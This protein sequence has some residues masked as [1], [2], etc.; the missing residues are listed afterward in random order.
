MKNKFIYSIA[1]LFTLF[2][3]SCDRGDV[4]YTQTKENIQN[5][6]N[7]EII[8]R[9]DV[10]NNYNLIVYRDTIDNHVYYIVAN[11]YNGGVTMSHSEDCMCKKIN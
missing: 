5:D 11:R 2:F 6:N 8:E 1:S 4:D 10:A 9:I 7:V 3:V